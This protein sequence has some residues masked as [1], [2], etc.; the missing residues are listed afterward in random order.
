MSVAAPLW[1]WLAAGVAAGVVVLHLLARRTP[2]RADFPTA[3]FVPA[4]PA[5]WPA[6]TR[7]PSDLALLL[8]RV[9]AVLLLGAAFARPGFDVSRPVRQVVL[10]D[11][12]RLVAD[13]AAALDSA[14]ARLSDGDT[15][16]ADSTGS[17]S[18]GLVRA[19]RA[20]RRLRE[21]ADS[22]ALVIVAPFVAGNVDEATDAVR[23]QWPGRATLVPVPPATIPAPAV[24][25]ALDPDDPLAATLGLAGIPVRAGAPVR[26]LRG[27]AGP[28]DSAWAR[29]GGV[30]LVWPSARGVTEEPAG[31]VVSGEVVVTGVRRA[32]SPGDGIVLARWRDGGPA[33]ADRAL[34]AGCVRTVGLDLPVASDAA[35]RRSTQGLLR[36]LLASCGGPLDLTPLSDGDR[37]RLAG[38]GPLLAARTLP[39]PVPARVPAVPWLLAAALALLGAETVVRRRATP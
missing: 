16:I 30:L 23:A 6:L 24:D 12:S 4:H 26:L 27:P 34:D 20:A 35:L 2:P 21:T 9:G 7:R 17:L 25:A 37:V 39:D 28:G 11:T 1:L 38:A 3:R 15:L 8:L 13:P 31:A 32:A 33:V 10:V 29:A 22:F 14:R 36:R 18:A 5:R 19:F